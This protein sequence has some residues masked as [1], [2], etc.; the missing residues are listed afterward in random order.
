MIVIKCN[1]LWGRRAYMQAKELKEYIS[2]DEDRLFSVLQ[3]SGFHDIWKASS[4]E[5]RCAT[6]HGDNK[7][8]VMIK[9][10]PDLY[11]AIF[12]S[13]YSGD[14]LGAIQEVMDTTFSD[15]IVFVHNVLG[16]ATN[17]QSKTKIDPLG[18]LKGL[19][20]KKIKRDR[21][22]NK[23]YSEA[24]LG[25][26][27]HLPYKT[28]IE[29]GIS[30]K[31][32]DQFNICFDPKLNRIIFPHYDWEENDRIVGIKGRTIQTKEELELTGTPKYWN[33]LTGY[34]KSHNI[35]GYNITKQYISAYSNII[36]FEGEKSVL[37]EYTFNKGKGCSVALGGHSISNEQVNFILRNVP[38]DCE[39]IIAFDKDV[40]T[41]E[42]EGE[43]FLIKEAMKFRPFRKVS[44]I[45]DKYNLLDEKD[46][47]IDKGFKVWQY[48]MKY[49]KEVK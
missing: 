16:I 46:S 12:S 15:V 39:I 8:G 48:L 25:A 5:I 9:V 7:T 22:S 41:K 47:P 21:K 35:Y 37:K 13:D 31:V 4:G 45:F 34:K 2:Q 27:I 3:A 17:S 33:Y 18:E 42:E 19:A 11:T 44:Y 32:L 40:M 6:P 26:F 43:Q 49:R 29:E 24:E 1:M 36:L 10:D 30:P 20:A 38:L 23:K 28:L 14:L